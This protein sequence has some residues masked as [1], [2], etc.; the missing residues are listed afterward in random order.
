MLKLTPDSP[1]VRVHIDQIKLHKGRVPRVWSNYVDSD[2]QVVSEAASTSACDGVPVALLNESQSPLHTVD[3]VKPSSKC[4]KIMSKAP[5]VVLFVFL[6]LCF[7]YVAPFSI[8]FHMFCEKKS[9][10]WNKVTEKPS[11]KRVRRRKKK[12]PDKF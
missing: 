5:T 3:D 6:A 7:V 11:C 10:V 4:L 9:V 1:E 12:P 2:E 8:P